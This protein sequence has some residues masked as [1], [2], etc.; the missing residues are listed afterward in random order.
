MNKDLDGCGLLSRRL[1][2]VLHLLL[3]FVCD[4]LYLMKRQLSVIAKLC[5]F[6]RES[7]RERERER[8]RGGAMTPL[9]FVF[10]DIVLTILHVDS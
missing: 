10:V 1:F 9:H 2:V 7:E 6:E 8:E 3:P 5:W 4:I